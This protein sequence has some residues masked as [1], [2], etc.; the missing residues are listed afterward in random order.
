VTDVVEIVAGLAS[1]RPALPVARDRA[2]HQPWVHGL[3]RFVSEIE[4]LHHAGPELL[5]QDV[6][7][8]NQRHELIA[9]LWALEIENQTFLAAVELREHRALAVEARL[10]VPH[11]LAARPLNLDDLC[12]G[13]GHHERR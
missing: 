10:V 9:G 8:L 13:F 7:A 12:A 11:V 6:G 3:E 2:V 5:D 4:P 1:A